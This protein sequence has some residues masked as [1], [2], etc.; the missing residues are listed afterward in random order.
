MKHVESIQDM[1]TRFTSIINELHSLGEIIPV[2]K[3]IRKILAVLP[4]SW[5]SKV[6]AINEAHDLEIMTM[7][8]LIGNLKTRELKKQKDLER[9]EPRKERKLVLKAARSDSSDDESDMAYLT[10]C[11]IR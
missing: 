9:Q 5:E 7:N 2:N 1:H 6:D 3:R 10:K 8:D 11:S 4:S